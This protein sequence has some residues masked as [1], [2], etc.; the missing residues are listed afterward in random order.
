M[1]VTWC[2][3]LRCVHLLVDHERLYIPKNVREAWD[4]LQ[5]FSSCDRGNKR[6]VETIGRADG[7]MYLS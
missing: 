5:T 7:E 4:V 6:W 2:K 1:W 3:G